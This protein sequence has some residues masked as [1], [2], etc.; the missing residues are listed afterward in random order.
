MYA[1]SLGMAMHKSVT[2]GV[3]VVIH[4][5]KKLWSVLKNSGQLAI[6]P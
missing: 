6:M 3:T 4:E 2:I 5:H 1:E